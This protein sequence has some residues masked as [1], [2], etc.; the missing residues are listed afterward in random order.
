MKITEVL[1]KL[2]AK[3]EVEPLIEATK[4]I[5]SVRYLKA[6]KEEIDTLNALKENKD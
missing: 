4:G 1:D 6:P 5:A 3:Y 2:N